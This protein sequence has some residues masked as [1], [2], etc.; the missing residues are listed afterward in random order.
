MAP[1]V[2]FTSHNKDILEFTLSGVNVSIANA[3]RRT[4]LADIPSIVFRTS[5]YEE[6]K[7]NIM[8][9]TTRL[10][11]ELLKQRL[12][13][14][15]IHVNDIENFPYKNYI[16]ELNMENTTDTTIIVTSK[17]FIVK[18]KMSGQP[19]SDQVNREIFPANEYGYY[20]DFVRLRPKT[21]AEIPGDK[22]HLTC[23]FSIGVAKE[24]G[25]FSVVSTS[26]YGFSVDEEEQKKVLEQKKL[27]WKN[28]GK[29]QDQIDFE[30]KNWLLLDGLRI[31][32]PDSFDFTVQSVGVYTNNELLDKA[33]A[34]LVDRLTDLD[35]LVVNDKLKVVTAQNTME[36]CYDIILE[37]E[38]YTIGKTLEYFLYSKYFKVDEEKRL[39]NFCG[40]KKMHPHDDE[41]IIRVAYKQVVDKA[42]IYGHLQECIRD[43]IAIFEDLKKKFVSALMKN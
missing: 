7:A 39:L 17:D 19:V 16:M 5:P 40:F 13:C 37:N 36:N 31:V 28:E 9:N 14:I 21:S 38:D 35:T 20:I 27:T 12:S 4:M 3:V 34:I 22:I 18:D 29:P 41:S 6:N 25:S 8:V 23:E 32:K 1:Q 10:N 15:P 11:N 30:A 33:C 43:S 26:A 24:E 42:I 2:K